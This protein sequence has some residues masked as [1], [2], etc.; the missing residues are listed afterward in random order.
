VI[1]DRECAL[2]MF[3]VEGVHVGEALLVLGEFR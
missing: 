2:G 3:P 1:E